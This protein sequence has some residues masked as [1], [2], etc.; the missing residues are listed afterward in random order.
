MSASVTWDI[1]VAVMAALNA[2]GAQLPQVHDKVPR[3]SDGSLLPRPYGVVSLPDATS[4]AQTLGQD[5]GQAD[6]LWVDWYGND[7]EVIDGRRYVRGDSQITLW[8]ALTKA[9][10]NYMVINSVDHRAVTIR[11]VQNRYL[12]DPNETVRRVQVEFR[13]TSFPGQG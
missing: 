12:G 11:W 6:R 5:S 8:A 10:L 2:V 1:R 7:E 9:E 13:V 3:A 4:T